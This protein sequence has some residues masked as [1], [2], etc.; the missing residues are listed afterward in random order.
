MN[1]VDNYFTPDRRARVVEAIQAAERNTSGEIRVHVDAHCAKDPL[2]R[3]VVCFKRL[4]MNRTQLRN[5]VLFYLAIEDHKFA[6][7]GDEGIDAVTADTFWEDI[8]V[9]MLDYFKKE[10]IVGALCW[11]IERAGE[12]L[13][14]HF[15]CQV[16][17]VNELS[18]EI[19]FDA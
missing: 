2:E 3:A 1:P 6:I 14:A 12:K 15:P 19:S 10:D 5:G 16:S 8:K 9:G 18:N 11:G 4:K 17:D 7:L 13:K